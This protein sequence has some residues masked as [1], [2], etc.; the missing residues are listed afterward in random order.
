MPVLRTLRTYRHRGG[1]RFIRLYRS[2]YNLLDRVHG[3]KKDGSGNPIWFGLEVEWKSFMEFRNWALTHGYAK[4]R[5][6]LDR[7][8]SQEGYTVKNCRWGTVAEN[9]RHSGFMRDRSDPLNMG[10]RRIEAGADV[11]F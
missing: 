10:G 11:P 5:C 1:K 6:S 8:E 3:V 2:W 4:L 9:S 7:R